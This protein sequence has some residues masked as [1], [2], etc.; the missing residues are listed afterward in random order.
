[1]IITPAPTWSNIS[2]AA[3]PTKLD[4][5]SLTSIRFVGRPITIV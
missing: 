5:W 1:M 3:A 2:S 4:V